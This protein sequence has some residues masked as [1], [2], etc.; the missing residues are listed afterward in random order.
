MSNVI[1][2]LEIFKL[3]YCIWMKF[4]AMF[5][6]ITSS[7]WDISQDSHIQTDAEVQKS[8]KIGENQCEHDYRLNEQVGTVCQLC[9]FVETEIKD[10]LPPFVS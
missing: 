3:N 8:S 4:C 10:I 2:P 7:L 1:F 9:G 6:L 5:L